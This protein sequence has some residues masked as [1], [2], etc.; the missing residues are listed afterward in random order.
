MQ[1]IVPRSNYDSYLSL[2]RDADGHGALEIHIRTEL[3]AFEPHNSS[4]PYAVYFTPTGTREEPGAYLC[5]G[6]E[7]LNRSSE[8]LSV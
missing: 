4:V 6:R 5:L 7:P 2:A 8:I 1:R 3:R